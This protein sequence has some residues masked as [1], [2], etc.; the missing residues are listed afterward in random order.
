LVILSRIRG[1]V[2]FFHLCRVHFPTTAEDE[3][4]AGLAGRRDERRHLIVPDFGDDRKNRAMR[5]SGW[6]W[7][8]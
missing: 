7:S 6:K 8:A 1:S 4:G 3:F 2:N 5:Y